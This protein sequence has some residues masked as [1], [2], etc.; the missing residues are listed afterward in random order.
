MSFAQEFTSIGLLPRGSLFHFWKIPSV[1][2][3]LAIT[4]GFLLDRWLEPPPLALGGFLAGALLAWIICLAG[5]R[6]GLALLYLF[7]V[8]ASLG[9]I[10][11]YF[12]LRW[13]S[14]HD[15]R[16][17]LRDQWQ[18]AR[19]RGSLQGEP[20]VWLP[21]PQDPLKSLPSGTGVT[22]L[23]RAEEMLL[24]GDWQPVQ[25]CLRLGLDAPGVG[26]HPGDRVEA[27]GRGRLIPG[28]SNPGEWNYREF[29]AGQG[30]LGDLRVRGDGLILLDQAEQFSLGLA[31][32]WVRENA[33]RVLA[34]SLSGP[35]ESLAEALLLGDSPGLDHQTWDKFRNT[36]V[37]HVLAISGQH[38]AILGGALMMVFRWCRVPTRRAALVV[39]AVLFFYALL[40]G[41]RPSAMRAAI[42]VGAFSLG[43]IC[44]RPAMPLHAMALAWILIALVQPGDLFSPGC[45]LSFLAAGCLVWIVPFVLSNQVDPLEEL[46][47]ASRPVAVQFLRSLFRNVKKLFLI[48]GIVWL[49]VSPLAA[50]ITH[51]VSPVGLLIGPPLILLTTIALLA[52][53]AG[54]LTGMVFPWLGNV[55]A[56]VIYPSLWLC[57]R[58]VDFAL[59]VP[60]GHFFLPDL[61]PWLLT[62]G[63]LGLVTWQ[64]NRAI[65]PR[66]GWLTALIAWTA[67]LVFPWRLAP[68]E[69][70]ATFLAVGHGGCVVLE[71]PSGETL[72]YD[73]G[74]FNG[75][76]V[77]RTKI[78]PFLWWRGIRKIDRVI[79]SHADLDHF[80]ALPAL[81]DYFP[82]GQVITNP[83]FFAKESPGVAVVFERLK[84]ARVPMETMRAGDGFSLGE[85]TLEAL[86]PPGIGLPG[87]ENIRSLVLLVTF[88]GKKM[89]LTGDLQP[90]GLEQVLRKP[91]QRVDILQAPHHGS[92][93]SLP[94]EFLDWSSPSLVVA[95]QGEVSSDFPWKKRLPQQWLSTREEG[96]ITVTLQGN[97]VT[98]RTY[99]TQSAIVL[100]NR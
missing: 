44:R 5:K 45:L 1:F 20:R 60:M 46:T 78:V 24:D 6:R 63:F 71:L 33:R 18:L 80:N 38:L 74:S 16:F 8:L 34:S 97:G 86:H 81:L 28:P 42:M 4:L 47:E 91:P 2:A 9:G 94:Q 14:L 26:L 77:A 3:A 29:L 75:P 51:V 96:A 85:A 54:L 22:W 23:I 32:A 13:V 83:S 25:G 40:T 57:N 27:I 67:L 31:L 11:H 92:P 59:A 73:T 87:V 35:E 56:L 19:V 21:S 72:L 89:L 39:T 30:V 68:R 48:S 99:S 70:R 69:L 64:I 76:E 95:S 82:I 66:W 12:S 52:G 53:F 98:V 41:A 37:L 55:A 36:G 7:L 88:R 79:L 58:L 17:H 93:A 49:T 50:G 65:L 84:R 62:L 43:A 61:S 10:R 90:P 100:L 15:I